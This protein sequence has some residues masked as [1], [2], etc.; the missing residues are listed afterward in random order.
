METSETAEVLVTNEVQNEMMGISEMHADGLTGNDMLIA[1][2]DAGFRSV[3][4]NIYFQHL[5]DNDQ[6][7]ATLDFRTN[8]EDVYNSKHDDHGTNV[9]SCIAGYK[10]GDFVSAVYDADVILCV[11]EDASPEHRI[12]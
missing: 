9:L 5:F 7:L 3:D 4:Q 6:V 10:A 2:F 11:T 8:S 12:E 1:V